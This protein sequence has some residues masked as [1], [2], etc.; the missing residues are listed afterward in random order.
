MQAHRTFPI[1]K[2]TTSTPSVAP[3]DCAKMTTLKNYLSVNVW[4]VTQ[5]N[6]QFC[7]IRISDFKTTLY[8]YETTAT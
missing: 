4:N 3:K 1:L 7:Q 6:Q 2:Y 5:K 8:F